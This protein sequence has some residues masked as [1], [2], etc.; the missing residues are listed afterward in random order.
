MGL[1]EIASVVFAR[2]QQTV[3]V[4]AQNLANL[5]TPGFRAHRTFANALVSLVDPESS[6]PSTDATDFSTGKLQNTASPYDLAI[7]GDGYFTVRTGDALAYTRDGQFHRDQDGHLVTASGAVLQA[8]NG[9]AIADERTKILSDGTMLQD[10]Q[11]VA[12]LAIA[13]F[14]NTQ[15]LTPAGDGCFTAPDHAAQDMATPNVRQGALEASNVSTADEMVAMMGALRSAES[16]QR[17]VQV[18]DDLMGRALTAFGQA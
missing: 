7:L 1:L 5:T 9:D 2:A 3:Q 11:A 8:D 13:M 4:S 14:D 18:Y 10:G 15:L 6:N 12:R 17:V 16:G